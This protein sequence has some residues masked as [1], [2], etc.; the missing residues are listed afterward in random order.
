MIFD[1]LYETLNLNI[2]S[3]SQN[4]V[5]CDITINKISDSVERG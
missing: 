4:I 5:Q 2:V 3:K 1:D